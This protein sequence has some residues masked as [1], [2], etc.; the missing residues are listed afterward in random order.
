MVFIHSPFLAN[1]SARQLD[2]L[3]LEKEHR[4]K[5]G[6]KNSL[7]PRVR[8][9]MAEIDQDLPLNDQKVTK[10]LEEDIE[11]V[12]KRTGRKLMKMKSIDIDTGS[13]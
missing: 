5:E 8:N 2:Q 10:K 6:L 4:R 3:A 11:R 9:I 13:D 12:Q 1:D 7:R